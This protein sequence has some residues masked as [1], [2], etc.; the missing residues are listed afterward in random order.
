MSAAGPV[1][2][3]GTRRLL[4]AGRVPRR[5]LVVFAHPVPESFGAAVAERAVSALEGSGHEVRVLDLYADDFDAR[6]SQ[7]EWRTRDTCVSWT[8]LTPHVDALRWADGLVFVYPT[9][10]GGQPAILKGWFDRVWGE[11]I[12]YDV[13]ADGSRVRGRLTN[14]ASIDVVTTHG[15]GKF[16][17][18]VQGEPGK[19]VILRGIRSMCGL[20]CRTSWIAFYGND[21]AKDSDRRAFLDRVSTTLA[22]K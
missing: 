22:K 21:Q 17:N 16:M 4:R 19:R 2:A 8:H 18:S 6:L 14:I 7:A 3:L 9:W 13:P 15:S 12:A 20:R 1:S 11:G 5:M 10:F